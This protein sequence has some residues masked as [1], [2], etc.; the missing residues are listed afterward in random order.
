[1]KIVSISRVA[2][3]AV[4]AK[5]IFAPNGRSLLKK[6]VVLQS[7][8]IS[9]LERL[10][11][12]YV[13]IRDAATADIEDVDSVPAEIRE[14]VLGRLETTFKRLRDP[15]TVTSMVSS[16]KLGRDIVGI[17][18]LIFEHLSH[19][20]NMIVNLSAMYS[21]DAYTLTHC[22]NVAVITTILGLAQGY[23]K[24]T[25]EELGLGAMVHDIGK[26]EVSPA[27]LNKPGKLTDAEYEHVKRHCRI[28]YEI[29]SSQPDVPRSS[30]LCALYH[31]EWYDGTGYP[32]GLKG[33]KIPE[34]ARLMSVA[35]VYDALTANRPYHDAWL[36]S[37]ALEFIFTQTYKQFDPQFVRLF[38]RHVNVYPVGLSV[39]LSNGLSGVVSHPGTPNLLRPHILV[40]HEADHEVKPYAFDLGEALNVTIVACH[41]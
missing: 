3:G 27:I 8:Y 36:P 16:G 20:G 22:M 11:V 30:P 10:G 25:V 21:S 4:L 39:K 34:F 38:V 6:D 23:S 37:D 14:E 12:P 13:Y 29:L 9:R 2:P 26:I 35:D 15:A 18:K 7:S 17:Y 41:V 33:E 32:E 5:S 19:T 40:T 24:D 31:H 28:G 1:M